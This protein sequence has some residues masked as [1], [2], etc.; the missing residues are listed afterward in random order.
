MIL[1]IE[2]YLSYVETNYSKIH[3]FLIQNFKKIFD[4][5]EVIQL[6]FSCYQ[7]FHSNRKFYEVI[8]FKTKHRF[9]IKRKK[10][11]S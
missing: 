6:L 9:F 11:K 3:K 10:I 5:I 7:N 1:H 2:E 8:D 4:D